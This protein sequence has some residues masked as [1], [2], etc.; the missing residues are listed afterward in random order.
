[1]ST[2]IGVSHSHTEQSVTCEE[3]DGHEDEIVDTSVGNVD[4]TVS[5][6]T[7]A[8]VLFVCALQDDR[9]DE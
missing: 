7:D 4:H 9:M 2:Y 8:Q 3:K 6:L 5:D 1:M